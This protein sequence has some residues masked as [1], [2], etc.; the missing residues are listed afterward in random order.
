[1]R[2]FTTSSRGIRGILALVAAIALLAG[3]TALPFPI[4]GVG[5][6]GPANGA[7]VDELRARY[8]KTG[9][10]EYG[11]DLGVVEQDAELMF[12]VTVEHPSSSVKLPGLMRPF[13]VYL[14]AELHVKLPTEDAIVW[15]PIKYDVWSKLGVKPGKPTLSDRTKHLELSGAG[16]WG[17]FPTLYLLQNIDPASGAKLAKPI[18]RT[19]SPKQEAPGTS[20]ATSVDDGGFLRLSWQPVAGATSY[21]I[22]KVS[23]TY[24]GS[25]T[26]VAALEVTSTTQT[27]WSAR[28][29]AQTPGGKPVTL[30]DRPDAQVSVVTNAFAREL[31]TLTEDGLLVQTP[32]QKQQ[33]AQ[34]AHER[35]PR[36]LLVVARLGGDKL[37]AASERLNLDVL[38][39]SLPVSF[40][41]NT[42][43]AWFTAHVPETPANPWRDIERMDQ[44]P[45][46]FPVTMGD[47]SLRHLPLQ[48]DWSTQRPGYKGASTQLTAYGR[49]AWFA[50][51]LSFRNIPNLEAEVAAFNERVRQS[52]PAGG[53]VD[54]DA[55]SERARALAATDLANAS[56]TAPASP[57]PLF[58]STPL[59]EY[60]A[61]NLMAGNE[62][63]DV[64]AWSESRDPGV[65]KDD[66]DE[67]RYQ[68]PLI[69]LIASDTVRVAADRTYVLVSFYDKKRLA[70]VQKQL[71]DKAAEVVRQVVRDD[72]TPLQKATALNDYLV[73]HGEYDHVAFGKM[74]TMIAG[75]P[76]P[77]TVRAYS[78]GGILLDGKGVCMSYAYAFTL[79]GRKAGL[80]V[81]TVDGVVNGH[82]SA[83]HAWNKVKLDGEWR[84]FD[85]TWNDSPAGNR[86]LNKRD[87]EPPFRDTHSE[88]TRYISDQRIAEFRSPQR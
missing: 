70:E 44:L 88:G 59:S 37:S 40:A 68:N 9:R 63:I 38:G 7:L 34:G 77:A 61:A 43:S 22:V 50:Q 26:Y 69:P 14:D 66:L 33:A 74:K 31:G 71:D 65:L 52:V 23:T 8:A 15:D 56:T 16:R 30:G 73:K 12:P 6:G 42:W 17:V 54:A 10:Y 67:A 80:E 41:L 51:Q 19:F 79:L 58:A 86:Y 84:A 13:E 81:V 87:D 36:A 57:Y 39:G 4:P 46:T 85:P 18:V 48:L 75:T 47:G 45:T 49:G 5:G 76:E 72:M 35:G 28:S 21:S 78:V 62:V 1:M 25:S 11:G 55:S 32:D 60:L 83:G 20:I 64:T 24:L 53:L 82:P 2:P 27:E 29:V 3:C